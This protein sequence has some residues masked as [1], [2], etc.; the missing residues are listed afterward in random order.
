MDPPQLLIPKSDLETLVNY[1]NVCNTTLTACVNSRASQGEALLEADKQ[2]KA[3]NGRLLECHGR[4]KEAEDNSS[5]LTFV[6]L[7]FLLGLV[8]GFA[9]R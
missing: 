3:C 2:L 4:V 8:A 9:T 5:F 7:A 1:G 6:P